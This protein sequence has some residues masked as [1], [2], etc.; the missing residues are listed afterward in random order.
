[1]KSM[2]HFSNLLRSAATILLPAALLIGLAGCRGAKTE[3]ITGTTARVT[4]VIDGKTIKLSN[5]LT[6]RL[7]GV[8]NSPETEKFLKTNVQG[9]KVKLIADSKDPKQTYVMGGKAK[10]NAYVN[11]VGDRL[12]NSVN[13][14]M[15]RTEVSQF[16]KKGVNDSVF[17]SGDSP[18]PDLTDAELLALLKPRTFL[19]LDSDNS[20]GTGFYISST[21]TALTNNHVLNYSNAGSVR[22]IPFS[23]EGGYDLSN[24]R[25]VER[26]LCTGSEENTQTDFTIFE[27]SLNGDKVPFLKLA[28]KH[29][30]DGN[31]VAKMGCV[32][33][34]PAHFSKGN[35]SHTLNGVV[36]HSST[37]NQ[38]DSGSPLVNAKGE[39]IGINQS[40]RVNQNF[41]G[42]A[43][44]Y[45]AVDIQ[46]IR[47]W[48]ENHRDDQG[49]LRY[50]R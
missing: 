39:V 44:V 18:T 15:I 42:D 8:E 5:N 19:I 40:I 33:G 27:V 13:G 25:K 50:G 14:R 17:I 41:G 37:M 38:G 6:V 7:L 31:E 49:Q 3:K 47:E 32:L 29:E 11:V 22:I 35:I 24:Y 23:E 34:E 16:I 28:K 9:K 12:L 26:I 48:F 46:L 4:E 10:V 1:M 30:T 36:S 2:N 21:G 20:L 43:G 45:K